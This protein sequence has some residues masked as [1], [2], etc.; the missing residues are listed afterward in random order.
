MAERRSFFKFFLIVYG[1]FLLM[2]VWEMG[3]DSWSLLAGLLGGMAVALIAHKGHGYLPSVFL[4]GHM[5][6]EWYHHAL[7]GSHY[8]T[9]E[10][11]FH[12]IHAILDMVFLYVEAK[13]HYSKYVLPFLSLV[14]LILI[15][16]FT[17]NYVPAPSNFAMS[18]LVVQ[19]LEVHKAVG[20]HHSHGGGILHHMVIGGMLG[21]VL[22]HLFLVPRWKHVH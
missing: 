19:A 22:S 1:G 9:G 10:V 5:I 2:H 8:N 13:E 17:Y 11:T 7:H 16:I 15:G 21:C 6:I 12:G 3:F 4:V 18:P 20:E 14:V